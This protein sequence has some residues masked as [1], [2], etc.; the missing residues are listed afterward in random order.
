MTTEIT[1]EQKVRALIG[2]DSGDVADQTFSSTQ[3]ATLQAM[4][5]DPYFAAI[6]LLERLAVEEALLLKYVKSYDMTIDGTKAAEIVLARA[7]RLRE[8]QEIFIA[9]TQNSFFDIVHVP[10]TLNKS[11][12]E[13]MER[14]Y[15]GFA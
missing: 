14:P 8:E 2:D 7:A 6:T 1:F 10:S 12:W 3:I 9:N 15:R 4:N 11:P 5:D 13:Y